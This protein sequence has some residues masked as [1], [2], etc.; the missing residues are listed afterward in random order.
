MD[1]SYKQKR[2]EIYKDVELKPVQPIPTTA[3][4]EE[5]YARLGGERNTDNVYQ[6]VQVVKEPP[7]ITS[8]TTKRGKKKA[9]GRK[10][11]WAIV[12]VL[13]SL[14]I[15]GVIVTAGVYVSAL[16]EN[17]AIMIRQI[18]ELEVRLNQTQETNQDQDINQVQRI[19]K[20]QEFGTTMIDKLNSLQSMINTAQNT[21]T[22]QLN[23]LQSSVDTLNTTTIAQLNSLQSSVDTD[24]DTTTAQLS[25]IQSSVDTLNIAKNTATTQLSSLQSSVNT[26]T[27]QVHSPVNLYQNCIQ[28]TRS[29]TNQSSG[30]SYLKFCTTHSLRANVVV[31]VNNS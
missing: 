14:A 19:N 26:L 18:K 10:C 16:Q 29:C 21:T 27:T 15:V 13:S 8:A 1:L 3:R 4:V 31:S 20:L 25:S 28:D 17:T 6:E 5:Q 23:S 11:L 30:S 9:N 7:L 22:G 24:R 12:L 2:D